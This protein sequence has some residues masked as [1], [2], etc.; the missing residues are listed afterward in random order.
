MEGTDPECTVVPVHAVWQ[1][2]QCPSSGVLSGGFYRHMNSEWGSA[3]K[4][5][6]ATTANIKKN[7]TLNFMPLTASQKINGR[8]F[9]TA[10]D[11]LI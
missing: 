7:M 4:K 11:I 2:Q 10:K 8:L 3:V 9:P 5:E 1:I 6:T